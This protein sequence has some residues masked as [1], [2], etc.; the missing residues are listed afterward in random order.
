MPAANER[1]NLEPEQA[2]AA[3]AQ[4]GTGTNTGAAASAA[5]SSETGGIDWQAQ[6]TENYNR[7][8][9]ARADYD[10]LQRRTEREVFRLVRQGKK[11][12]LIRLLELADNMDRASAA[13]RQ[14]LSGAQG[15]DTASLVDGVV[16]ISRQLQTVLSAEG[17]QPIEA[18]GKPFDPALHEAVAMWETNQ[19]QTD[20]VSDEIRRGY[21][22]DGEVLRPAQVRVARPP[23]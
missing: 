11:D 4:A 18:V 10:N 17:V 3:A 13:W 5:P 9:R 15:F 6:A 1:R 7:F 21:T 16:M 12:I 14:T 20:T 19:V 8:L 22:H 2:G 23:S